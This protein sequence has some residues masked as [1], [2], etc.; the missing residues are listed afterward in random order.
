MRIFLDILMTIRYFEVEENF[1]ELSFRRYFVEIVAWLLEVGLDL[2]FKH[3]FFVVKSSQSGLV[4]VQ[5]NRTTVSDT[6]AFV[7]WDN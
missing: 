1:D 7:F 4:C 5:N 3:F 2:K 6:I